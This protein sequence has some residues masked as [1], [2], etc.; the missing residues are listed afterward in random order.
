MWHIQACIPTYP[1]T[2]CTA[3]IFLA[4]KTGE[5]ENHW[6]QGAVCSRCMENLILTL[7]LWQLAAKLVRT[8]FFAAFWSVLISYLIFVWLTTLFFSPTL[9]RFSPL[10][11]LEHWRW[12]SSFTL[13]LTVRIYWFCLRSLDFI[14]WAAKATA[15]VVLLMTPW[16]WSWEVCVTW[17][18]LHSTTFWWGGAQHLSNGGKKSFNTFIVCKWNRL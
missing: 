12:H 6:R 15:D 10:S 18:S 5:G 1:L 7:D 9:D 17:L 4:L 13:S 16:R 2:Y 8:Q 3:A 11:F 14:M